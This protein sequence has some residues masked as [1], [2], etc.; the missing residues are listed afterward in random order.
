MRKFI[1][2]LKEMAA[3]NV[4]ELDIEFLNRAQKITSFNLKTAD[5]ETMKYKAEIQH[6]FHRH[7]FPKFDL[8][9]TL[10]GDI[11]MNGANKIIKDLKSIDKSAFAK[12]H[13]YNLKGVGPGEATLF[14]ICDKAVL[15][16]GASAGVDVIIAGNK[17][18]VKAAQYSKATNTVYG[19]K[20]GGTVPLGDMV[21]K[22]VKLKNSLG[23]RTAG[24]GQNEVNKSQ[25]DAIRKKFPQEW[26]KIEMQY[27]RA[28][29][30][31]FGNTP[32]IFINNNGSGGRLTSDGGEIVSIK[33]VKLTDIQIDTIT[34][35]TIKPRVK[36]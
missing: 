13:F 30:K 3:V 4:N 8:S 6:L 25:I 24:K 36:I 23:M 15:G 29:A 21:T 12:L 34:Q 2:H 16:G 5:F 7:F 14:F 22:A 9:K 32:V 1:T 28:S 27:A 26:K 31:Y 10:G 35:G 33:K 19:F 18:E 11:T 17:Y 20:L